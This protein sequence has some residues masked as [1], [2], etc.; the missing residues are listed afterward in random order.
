MILQCK[1]YHILENTGHADKKGIR[2]YNILGDMEHMMARNTG[3][4]TQTEEA[5]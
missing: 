4:H 2:R 1:I 3:E 5:I